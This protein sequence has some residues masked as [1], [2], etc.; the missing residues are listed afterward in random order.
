MESENHEQL[1]KSAF[2]GMIWKF[3][4]RI[5]AQGVAFIVSIVLARLLVPEDYAPIGIV[6]ILIIICNIFVTGG[7]SDALI[8]KKDPCAEDFTAVLV[9]NLTLAVV[10]Y[11]LLYTLAPMIAAV[12]R[13]EILVSVIRT[14]SLSLIIYAIKAVLSAYTSVTLQF[15][16]FFYSTIVG[17]VI[18][19]VVGI[20]L[21]MKGLGV[22]ALVAQEMT[23]TAI[24]T[25]VLSLSARMPLARRFSFARMM[26]LVRYGWKIMA[27]SVI[28]VIF[29]YI[30]PLIVGFRF[31]PADL[32]YYNKGDSFPNLINSTLSGTLASVLLPVMAKVQ[33]NK[34]DILNI[35]RRY[36]KVSSYVIFPAMLGLFAVAETF[37]AVLLT[38]K[39]LPAV[40]F[41]RIFA[42]IYMFDLIQVGNIQ[43]L[44]AI[45][46]SDV[47]LILDIIKK[48]VYFVVILLF[49]LLSDSAV[50]LAVSG[51]VC[52]MAALI[53]NTFPTTKL[54]GYKYAYQFMDFLPNLIISVM[55][56]ALVL[57]VGELPLA[58]SILLIMQ[59]AVGVI[60][61][62]ILSI[63]S[64]N[65]SFFYLLGFIRQVLQRR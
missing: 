36:V 18:S 6:S 7:M 15:R 44:R 51:I 54:I 8:R 32:S 30:K 52:T 24:D 29:D 65:S 12:Y 58:N 35:T 31:T 64:R 43:A 61:Y 2:G 40:P 39:W 56:G 21:A 20:T 25:L 49:V 34:E 9:V 48:S 50:M 37:I 46:R 14:M 33:D 55:M 16:K 62:V 27:S 3:M 60:S 13:M 23:N 42:I 38:E 19:A 4:E 53:I 22:W 57:L 59:V 26:E 63:A 47:T 1:K 41:L 11:A 28:S 17:T 45:G 5:C 10:M